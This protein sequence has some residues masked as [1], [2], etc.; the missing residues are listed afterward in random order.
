MVGDVDVFYVDMGVNVVNLS[1][2][3]VIIFD[4]VIINESDGYILNLGGFIVFMNGVYNFNWNVIVYEN[5][6]I[7]IE[8]IYF[9]MYGKCVC[10]SGDVL[11][12]FVIGVNGM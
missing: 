12:I 2:I 11:Y 6:N 1:R 10:V 3:Y 8:I 7:F 5:N 9:I 4:V